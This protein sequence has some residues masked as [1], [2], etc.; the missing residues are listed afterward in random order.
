MKSQFVK[1]IYKS[2]DIIH[3]LYIIDGKYYIISSSTSHGISEC[4]AFAADRFGEIIDYEDLACTRPAGTFKECLE[5]L[6]S[7]LE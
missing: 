4:M 1:T 7:N 6:K 2:V 5:I 3:K